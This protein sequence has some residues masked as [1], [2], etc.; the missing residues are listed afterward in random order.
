MRSL[1]VN[2]AVELKNLTLQ[3]H[4]INQ[5]SLFYSFC[6]LAFARCIQRSAEVRTNKGGRH[7]AILAA[8]FLLSLYAML[9]P[10]VGLAVP[11]HSSIWGTCGSLVIMAPSGWMGRDRSLVKVSCTINSITH[12]L[13]DFLL[14]YRTALILFVIIF[15]WFSHSSIKLFI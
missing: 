15:Y 6:P 2:R 14:W 10:A 5:V 3:R 9:Q 12:T 1:I 4:R 11:E 8:P 13:R 7:I